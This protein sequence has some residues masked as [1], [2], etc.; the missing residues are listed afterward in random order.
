MAA[1]HV[2]GL[3]A[4]LMDAQ[5]N[6]IGDVDALE[7]AIMR[8]AVPLYTEQGCGGDEMDSLPNHV[9]GWGRI[10]AKKAYD[11]VSGAKPKITIFTPILIDR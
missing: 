4:L 11:A 9:Y 10:D 3:A 6:L 2:A 8:S 1:P 7:Q 5:P